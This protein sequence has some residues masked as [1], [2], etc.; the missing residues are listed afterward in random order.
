MALHNIPEGFA[1]ASAFAA[2]PALG[3]LVTTS[4]AIQDVPEGLVASAPLAC[5]GVSQKRS[6]FWGVFSGFAEFVAAIF[7]FIFLSIIGTL[8]PF[9]LSFSAGAMAYVVVFELLPDA[10]KGPMRNLSAITFIFG[11]VFAVVLASFFA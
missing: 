3:W 9:A 4:I 6:I 7:G 10:L 5:C 11:I 1:I 2:S 8:V